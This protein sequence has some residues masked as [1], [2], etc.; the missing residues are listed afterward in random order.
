MHRKWSDAAPSRRTWKFERWKAKLKLKG[1]Q[2]VG[3]GCNYTKDISKTIDDGSIASIIGERNSPAFLLPM[4][5][6]TDHYL[7]HELLDDFS[8]EESLQ[9]SGM[10]R[11]KNVSTAGQWLGIISDERGGGRKAEFT[12]DGW[13][14]MILY[15]TVEIARGPEHHHHQLLYL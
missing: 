6:L 7:Q 2:A 1:S 15:R 12:S 5:Y 11:R 10:S 14:T 8:V 9:E 4:K 3:F 13:D